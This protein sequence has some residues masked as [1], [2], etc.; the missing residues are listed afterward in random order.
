MPSRSITSSHSRSLAEITV[1]ANYVTNSVSVTPVHFQ[2]MISEVVMLR[3]FS[4]ME[5]YFAEIALK[6]ACGTRYRNGNQP[7][8][9]MQC[10]SVQDA[11]SKMLSHNRRQPKLYLKWTTERFIRESI[12][13]ILNVNDSF[14]RNIQIH[15]SLINEMRI[16]RNHIA[17]KTTTTRTDYLRLLR[18]LYGANPKLSVGAF[19]TSTSRSPIS[20]I[21]RYTRSTII[22]LNDI[23]LG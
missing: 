21:D 23:T 10:R 16:V 3:L 7:L 19:L 12:E 11:Y 5:F 18:T 1:L 2:Y 14:F 9:H 22:M 20:N 8:I 17:H 15:A 4:I 6:L 13:H